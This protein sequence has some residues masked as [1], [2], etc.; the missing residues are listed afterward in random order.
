MPVDAPRAH[1]AVVVLVV[2]VV[3]ATIVVI[4]VVKLAQTW[5]HP[6]TM[7]HDHQS[8]RVKKER[9][10]RTRLKL[11]CAVQRH[12]TDRERD[13]KRRRGSG[14]WQLVKC[15]LSVQIWRR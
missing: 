13:G 10:M 7:Q 8:L 14:F 4:V 11:K 15:P 3:V 9:S 5:K 2:I 12:E 6:Y 1:S